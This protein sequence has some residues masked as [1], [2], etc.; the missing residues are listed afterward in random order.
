M[1]HGVTSG[2]SPLPPWLTRWFPNS[3]FP[4]S[5][6][7]LP[8]VGKNLPAA[9]HSAV[10]SGQ[11]SVRF[12]RCFGWFDP[13]KPGSPRAVARRGVNRA[14]RAQSRETFLEPEGIDLELDKIEYGKSDKSGEARLF[15]WR[16]QG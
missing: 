8:S 13:R 5:F 9:Q 12:S 1:M 16:R 2:Q 10:D 7:S 15:L 3:S 14:F 6:P 4:P 11:V